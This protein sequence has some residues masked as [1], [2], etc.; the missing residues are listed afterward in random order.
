MK[1][2]SFDIDASLRK[3]LRRL[4]KEVRQEPGLISLFNW[5]PTDVGVVPYNYVV[6]PFSPELLYMYG[7]QFDYSFPQMFVGKAKALLCT[8]DSI[9]MVNIDTWDSLYKLTLYDID[10]PSQEASIQPGNYWHLIDLEESWFLTNG[11]STVFFSGKD[12]MTGGDEKVYIKNGM[13]VSC[14][15]YYKGR[16]VLGGFDYTRFWD[17]TWQSFWNSWQKKKKDTGLD[18]SREEAEGSIDMPVG[19]NWI[20]WSSIGGGDT[21]LLFSSS[22]LDSGY[23]GSTYGSDKPFVFD[24]LKRNEQGF[25]QLPF[26]GQVIKLKE[27]GDYLIAY[28]KTGVIA[29]K[30]V[31]LEI[32][33]TL[34]QVTIPEL[35]HVGLYSTGAVDGDRNHHVFLDPSGFLWE[36]GRDLSV[37]PLGYREYLYPMIDQNPVI[38]FASRPWGIDQYGEF[39]ICTSDKTYKLVKNGLMETGQRLSSARYIAGTCVGICTEYSDEKEAYFATD[40]IDFSQPGYKTINSV[41]VLN[42][43]IR[44]SD[45]PKVYVAIDYRYRQSGEFVTGEYRQCNY[46]GVATFPVS[47]V[48]FRVRVKT[49]NFRRIDIGTVR[50]NYQVNDRRFQRSISVTEIRG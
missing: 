7:I 27:L 3:G 19:K 17:S 37:V 5:E 26:T 38:Y 50:I 45:K 49:D 48:D 46:E 2:F 33:S 44:T 11:A 4:N 9:Y 25:S 12:V 39:F 16:V 1:E 21:Q 29:L 8:R 42:T 15:S 47:G 6:N 18:F 36:L 41:V 32:G 10:N 31:G 28:T 13:P 24:L 14:G 43:E 30:H 40:V 34:A 23:V 20:W 35:E 22:L